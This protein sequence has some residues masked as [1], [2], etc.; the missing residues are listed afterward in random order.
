M[1][2]RQRTAR[3]A[4]KESRSVLVSIP[5]TAPFGAHLNSLQLRSPINF[6]RAV[7][8]GRNHWGIRATCTT[9]SSNW[10]KFGRLVNEPFGVCSTTNRVFSAGEVRGVDSREDTRRRGFPR[11]SC[12]GCIAGYA[13]RPEIPKDRVRKH[14]IKNHLSRI[15]DKLGVSS[16]IELLFM[17]LSHGTARL[18]SSRVCQRTR[19]GVTRSRR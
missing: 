3:P 19:A 9:P 6:R 17:T 12:Y 8:P 7:F 13:L 10:Q 1:N 18:H 14:I 11:Q 15:F 5:R 16:R 2:R 4:L